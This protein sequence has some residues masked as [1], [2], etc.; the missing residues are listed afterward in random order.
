MKILLLISRLF[1]GAL[2]IFSGIIKANDPLGFAYKLHDYFEVFGEYPIISM[3]DSPFFYSIALEMSIFICIIEVLLGLA[4]IL[5]SR[6]K[7]VAW[8]LLLM[9][10]FFTFLTGF[11]AITGK[12]TDCGCFGDAIPL[13]PWQSFYKDII[14]LVFI[15]I[16]FIGRNRIRPLLSSAKATNVLMLLATVATTVFT[17][18]AYHH[19]PFWDFRAY[20][21]G[22]DVCE[23]RQSVP[24][25]MQHYYTLKNRA[26]GE[27]K[28]FPSFPENYETE[29]EYVSMRSEVVETGL[30]AKISNFNLSGEEGD[31]T[32]EFL[33]DEG[34]KFLVVCYD[35][36]KTR[37]KRFDQINALQEAMAARGVAFYGVSAS[38]DRDVEEFRHRVQAAFPFLA[39]D[40][41]EL[42]TIIRSNPGLVMMKGCEVVGKWHWRDVPEVEHIERQFFK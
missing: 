37:S 8:T 20:K 40:G 17:L 13:T 26:S 35:I 38:S 30:P 6:P 11:S 31:F 15:G 29:W 4:L 14:L 25:K 18:Y 19:L 3:F 1:V 32:D 33:G 27:Q 2:F 9:I 34:Y 42:K 28:E 41:T 39:A 21:I 16:I 36:K 12:V 5:G 22:N 10:V 24:D 7:L 23:L